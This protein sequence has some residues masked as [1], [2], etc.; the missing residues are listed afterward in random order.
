VGD[1]FDVAPAGKESL[2]TTLDNLIAALDAGN[3]TPQAGAEL[4]SS[5]SEALAQLDQGLGHVIDL[6]TEIGSRLSALD[7][8]EGL[9]EDLKIQLSGS[10][11]ELQDLDYAEAIGRLNQQ[12]TGLQAAQAAYTRIGQLSLFDYM[13]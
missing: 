2:F 1:T 10:L 7:T 12:M 11:S 9:R 6:R 8:A 13:R 3:G 5:I 4:G